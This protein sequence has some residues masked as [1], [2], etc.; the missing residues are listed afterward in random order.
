MAFAASSADDRVQFNIPRQ[1]A[2]LALILFAEQADLTLIVPFEDVRDKT[3]NPVIGEFRVGEAALML[4]EGTGLNATFREQLVLA[5]AADPATE[6]VAGPE[7]GEMNNSK[8]VHLGAIL[9]SMFAATGAAAQDVDLALNPGD[10]VEEIIV[11]GTR[12]QDRSFSGVAPVQVINPEVAKLSGGFTATDI[13]RSSSLATGSFQLNQQL[14]RG[15][16]RWHRRYRWWRYKQHFTSWTRH[17]ALTGRAGRAA[18]G[19]CRRTWPG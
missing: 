5:I 16:A 19:T 6:P 8:T 13:I 7:G 10:E 12:L 1:R 11:T 2:D 4:L 17:T 9:A 14:G 3:A 18:P 15:I